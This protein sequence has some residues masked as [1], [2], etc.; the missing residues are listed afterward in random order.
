MEAVLD[1]ANLGYVAVDSQGVRIEQFAREPVFTFAHCAPEA[2]GAVVGDLAAPRNMSDVL[3]NIDAVIHSAGLAHG[4]SGLPEDDYRAINT[5]ATAP[6]SSPTVPDRSR[7][8][9]G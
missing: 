2:S 9:W 8:G 7:C 4:M 6:G 5:E 3:A 1:L